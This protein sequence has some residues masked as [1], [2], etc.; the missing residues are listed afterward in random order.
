MSVYY[1]FSTYLNKGQHVYS[2]GTKFFKHV[3]CLKHLLIWV[4]QYWPWPWMLTLEIQCQSLKSWMAIG[5]VLVCVFKG[6]YIYC[7]NKSCSGVPRRTCQLSMCNMIT[8]TNLR[9][10]CNLKN[11]EN[12]QV[13]YFQIYMHSNPL[14]V[15]NHS[16]IPFSR[17]I[18]NIR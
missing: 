4:C 17:Q 3:D 1:T 15:K 2:S 9:L 6:G 14:V 5:S 16:V 13:F 8:L 7:R 10:L 12:N 18:C 11:L